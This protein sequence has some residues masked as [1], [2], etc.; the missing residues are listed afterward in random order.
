M[1]IKMVALTGTEKRYGR[2]LLKVGS[3]EVGGQTMDYDDYTPGLGYRVTKVGD[4]SSSVDGLFTVTGKNIVT[5]MV[6]EVTSVIATTTSLQIISSVGSRTWCAS[7][8]IITEL[9]GTLYVVTGDP[10]DVLTGNAS[11]VV[12]TATVK[13]GLRTDV[14]VND[15]R[16]DQSI[17]GAGTG[18]IEWTLYYM[19]LEDGAEITAAA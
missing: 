7:T 19:P 2:M 15:N 3:L 13:T 5:L 1:E 12:G 8:E 6:G 4:V 11:N 18:L 16:I 14:L 17:N 9:V 10:D